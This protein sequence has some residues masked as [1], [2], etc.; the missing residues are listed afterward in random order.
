MHKVIKFLLTFIALAT[1]LFTRA[2][3]NAQVMDAAACN[4]GT[5]LYYHWQNFRLDSRDLT[6]QSTPDGP[7]GSHTIHIPDAP[8]LRLKFNEYQ[9]TSGSYIR[10]TSLEDGSTQRFD[11][12]S[13]QQWY[14]KSAFF[15]GDTLKIEL[16]IAPD[17]AGDFF[18]LDKLLVGEASPPDRR[19]D[20]PEAYDPLCDGVDG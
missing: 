11:A 10:I 6:Y 7:V 15:N 17:S 1:I 5:G 14:L 18:L 16:Y 20:D 12:E 13:L 3:D 9:L 8:W 19:P 4:S 2:A